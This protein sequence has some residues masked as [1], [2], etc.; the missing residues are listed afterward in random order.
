MPRRAQMV[1]MACSGAMAPA[2]QVSRRTFVH[3]AAV[4]PVA[5]TL[6]AA[7]VDQPGREEADDVRALQRIVKL[8]G[9][10]QSLTSPRIR[11]LPFQASRRSGSRG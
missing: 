8:W 4:A 7:A 1:A 5:L 6:G 2:G 3:A 10:G 9:D 11:A